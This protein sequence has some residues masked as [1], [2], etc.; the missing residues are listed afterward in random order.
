M[1]WESWPWKKDL[2]RRSVALSKRTNQRRWPEASLANVE[3]DVFLSAYIIRK[4]LDAKKLSDEVES[5][6]LHARRS[7]RTGQAPDIMNWH[8]L[9]EFYDLVHAA[10][11]DIC[12]RGFCDQIIHSFVFVVVA[13]APGLEGFYVASDRE[14]SSGLFYFD[15]KEVIRILKRIVR[16][17]IVSSECVRDQTTGEM[18]V[19]RKSNRISATEMAAVRQIAADCGSNQKRRGGHR[20]QTSQLSSL[21]NVYQ[22]AER[23]STSERYIRTTLRAAIDQ[24]R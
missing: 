4:L 16:D 14:R 21:W 6:A 13:S 9:D 22:T 10:A 7:I 24:R 15:I 2:E 19:V 20:C 5:I 23:V 18:K 8:R 3:Q 17:D 1:I 12:L 11:V